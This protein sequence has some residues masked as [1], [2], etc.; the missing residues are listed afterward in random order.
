MATSEDVNNVS[1]N[2]GT[3]MRQEDTVSLVKFILTSEFRELKRDLNINIVNSKSTSL[4]R[5]Y[6]DDTCAIKSTGNK[7]KTIDFNVSILEKVEKIAEVKDSL[8]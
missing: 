7:K 1:E 5:K 6:S 3:E 8:G 4:K 2:S